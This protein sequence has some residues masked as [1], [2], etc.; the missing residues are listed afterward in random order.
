VGPVAVDKSLLAD[1]DEVVTRR[2][3]KRSAFPTEGARM[4]MAGA[5]GG[6]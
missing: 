3:M 5:V 2:D 4:P 6:A 1:I